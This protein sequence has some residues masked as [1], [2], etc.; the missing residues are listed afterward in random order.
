MS[1]ICYLNITQKNYHDVFLNYY[2]FN[3]ALLKLPWDEFEK[4][5]F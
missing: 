2:M 4:K 5:L 3:K 1:I